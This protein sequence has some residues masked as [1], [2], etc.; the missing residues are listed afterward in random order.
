MK[1][2]DIHR[3]PE[4]SRRAF[5]VASS[6]VPAFMI[7]SLR[8]ISAAAPVPRPST[9]R[10]DLE[11]FVADC[12]AASRESEPQAAVL[13]VLARTVRDPAAV[14]TALGEATEAGIRVLHRSRTLT[15]FSATW[16]PNMNLMPHDHRMWAAIGIYTGRED[17]ILWRRSP[18]RIAADSAKALFAGDAVALEANAI[19]SV[20]NPLPRFTGGL[21]VYGGD[22]FDT[23]RSHWNPETLDEEPSNG[24]TIRAIFRKENERIRRCGGA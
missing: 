10:M 24:E 2:R 18:D 13:E 9:D 6:G 23:A 15:I 19:H 21:H 20:T 5:L 1:E 8:E 16:A 12:V 17:N 22:F 11:R 14:R 3:G 7:S 4:T